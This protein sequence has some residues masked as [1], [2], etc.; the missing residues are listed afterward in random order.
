MSNQKTDQKAKATKGSNTGPMVIECEK[1]NVKKNL[2]FTELDTKNERSKSQAIC[3]P[4]YEYI[5]NVKKNFIFKTGPIKLVQYGITAINEKTKQW[6][7]SDKDREY[8]RIPYNPEDPNSVALFKMLEE[9]DEVARSQ[10][11]T[12]FGTKSSQYKYVPLVKE[13]S[14][15][16]EEE[17]DEEEQPKKSDKP[18]EPKMKFC[19]VKLDAEY[20]EEREI[21]TAVFVDGNTEPLDNIKTVSDV[22]EH[23]TWQSTVRF[24]IMM[25]KLWAEKIPKK[26]GEQKEFGITM[27]CMQL[28]VVE[29]AVKTGSIKTAFRKAFAFGSSGNS[30]ENQQQLSSQSESKPE[31]KP[32]SKSEAKSESKPESSVKVAD[33]KVSKQVEQE[34]VEEEEEAGDDVEEVEEVEEPEPENVEEPEPESPKKTGKGKSSSTKE[35]E[36]LPS[37]PVS[38]V[39]KGR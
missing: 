24:I 30:Q 12:I 15:A 22:A 34:E 1:T 35:P 11:A 32:E 20:T 39:T 25:N 8:V 17:N 29:R 33:K 19:K 7:K 36:K 21:T 26:K 18:K 37:K 10:Q 16:T 3:Y 4:N 5:P 23:V 9:A 2:T 31:S 13:P 27:K 38:K 6:I 28:E 14:E